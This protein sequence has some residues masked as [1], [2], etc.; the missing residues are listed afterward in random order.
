MIVEHW[1]SDSGRGSTEVLQEKAGLILNLGFHGEKTIEVQMCVFHEL[2]GR[3]GRKHVAQMGGMQQECSS[4]KHS[5][6][7]CS[8]QKLYILST[9]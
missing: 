2:Q 1:C 6:A 7:Y 4:L 5:A 3:S 9:M 8:N